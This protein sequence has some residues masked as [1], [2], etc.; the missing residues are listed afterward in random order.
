M[1]DHPPYWAD[2]LLQLV[3]KPA[4]RACI[5]GDL[6]EEY[7][8]EIVPTGGRRSADVWYCGQVFGYVWRTMRLWTLLFSGAFIARTAFDWGVPTTDFTTRSAMSTAGGISI[9][10]VTGLWFGWRSGSVI[11]GVVLTALMTQIAAVLSATAV[12]VMLML[13]HSTET[14]K[15]IHASGGFEEA[16]VLP[17]M[18]I[19]PAIV[20]GGI[21][22]ALGTASRRILGR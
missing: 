14:M 8:A 11:S 6:L 7:R 19:I 2:E 1:N 21:G 9:L 5:S 18:M 15:S 3:L 17:F 13:W 4:D 22:G 10:L 16:V 20:M 12:T